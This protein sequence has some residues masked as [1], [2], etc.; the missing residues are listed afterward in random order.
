MLSSHVWSGRSRNKFSQQVSVHGDVLDARLTYSCNVL[1]Q[2]NHGDVHSLIRFQWRL[3]H[4]CV[5][6]ERPSNS[7]NVR[8]N[9]GHTLLASSR[10]TLE[11]WMSMRSWPLLWA[12][13]GPGALGAWRDDQALYPGTQEPVGSLQRARIYGLRSAFFYPIEFSSMNEEQES[14]NSL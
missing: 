7:F 4:A 10:E 2:W 6:A 5:W 14:W 12:R 9:P 8:Y 13:A 11:F 3:S 1:R